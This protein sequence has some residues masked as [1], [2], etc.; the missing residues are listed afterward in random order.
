MDSLNFVIISSELL[1]L[2]VLL[3]NSWSCSWC[4]KWEFSYVDSSSW[5]CSW[6]L[7][8]NKTKYKKLNQVNLK[9]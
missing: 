6:T 2:S 8:K 3:E 1:Y 9:I 4:Q 5:L 7:L